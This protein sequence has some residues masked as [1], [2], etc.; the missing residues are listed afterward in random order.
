[1]SRSHWGAPHL[2]GADD[3]RFN[4]DPDLGRVRSSLLKYIPA[5]SDQAGT[6]VQ[7][8][9]FLMEHADALERTCLEGHF[10]ASALVIAVEGERGLLTLHKKLG[11][12]LQVGGH[13]DGDGNLAATA[14]REATEESG[15]E[16]LEV[17]PRPIDLDMHRIPA[18][19]GEPE[20][21]HLD[22]RFLVYAPPQAELKMSD[23]SLDLKW[24]DFEKLAE[25]DTDESVRRLFR[26]AFA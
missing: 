19:K 20:H 26:I 3:P 14:L 1:M 11:R 21:W 18:C 2:F 13:C 22:A 16:D 8:L 4:L 25:I 24:I 17:D 23:E 10:T 9:S 7:M 6:R 15:I 12:W 5:N